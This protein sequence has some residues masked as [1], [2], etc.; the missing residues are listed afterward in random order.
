MWG[1]LLDIPLTDEYTWLDWGVAMAPMAPTGYRQDM[2]QMVI[3]NPKRIYRVWRDHHERRGG[4]VLIYRDHPKSIFIGDNNYGWRRR[5][6]EAT[7]MARAR[8]RRSAKT[9]QDG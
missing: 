4:L 7:G 6:D 9:S 1:F 5:N 8:N 2:T 3:G